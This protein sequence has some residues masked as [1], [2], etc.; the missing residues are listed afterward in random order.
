MVF[1]SSLSVAPLSPRSL[2][3]S[4]VSVSFVEVRVPDFVVVAGVFV[5]VAPTYC[6]TE[7]VVARI[8][9][10]FGYYHHWIRWTIFVAAP[11]FDGTA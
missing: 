4:V 6:S 8:R 5:G 7:G 9:R 2:V 3:G 10:F 1:A 11:C